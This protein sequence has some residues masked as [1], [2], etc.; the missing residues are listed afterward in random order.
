MRFLSPILQHVLYPGLAQVG[1]FHRRASSPLRVVT[2]HGVLPEAYRVTDPFLDNTL[3]G[4]TAFR[5]QLALLKKHYNVIAPDHFLAWLRKEKSLPDR[6]VLL[7]CDD[8]LL[9]NLTTMV[10]RLQE[11]GLQCL[12]FVTASSLEAPDMLW[13]VE[14]YLL[15]RETPGTP[16]SMEWRGASIPSVPSDRTDRIAC[17]LQLMKILSRFDAESRRAFLS[18]AAQ[19]WGLTA[20]WKQKF[21]DDPLLRQRFQ[22]MSASD[23]RQLVG[24]GMTIGAHTLSH[25]VLAEQSDNLARSEI[26]DCRPLLEKCSGHPVWAIAYPF[27]D[28]ASVGNREYHLAESAGYECGFLNVGGGVGKSFSAFA[29]PRI[30]VTAEMSLPVYEAHVSGFHEALRARFLERKR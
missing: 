28:P 30:H 19:A 22:L 3:L 12:F 21:F 26:A 10:P 4:V 6:A 13:Y 9:N 29:L 23:L 2:Y 27:G 8:G 15:L 20:G 1:Y 17:W 16:R 5:S 14:L 11:Q 18:D 25:P 7:T 24:Q